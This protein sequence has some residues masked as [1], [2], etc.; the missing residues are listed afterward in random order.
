[1]KTKGIEHRR[2]RKSQSL[3]TK[4]ISKRSGTEFRTFPLGDTMTFPVT[5]V[6]I[7]VIR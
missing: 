6:V 4:R 5:K 3:Q 2:A 7:E 1:M